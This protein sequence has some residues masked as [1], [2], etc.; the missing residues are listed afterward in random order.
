MIAKIVVK[1]V[2]IILAVAATVFLVHTLI[3]DKFAALRRRAAVEPLAFATVSERERQ[4]DCMAQ[5]IY[6]EAANEPAEGK[7]AVAQVV[8]NR[9]NSGKFP[10]DL[11]R[12]IYQKNVAYEHV[13]CQFSWYCQQGKDRRRMDPELYQ[14]SMA[15]A[16]K[17]V[18]EGFRLPALNNALYYHADYVN[19]QWSKDPVIKIGRHIFYQDHEK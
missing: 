5:N 10:R 4:L 19:P 12:V 15:A 14:E 2:L 8:V 6:W 11:C 18:M 9:A 17:V 7:I 16:T 3:T 13:I 1:G